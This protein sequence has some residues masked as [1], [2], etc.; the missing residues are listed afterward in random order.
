MGQPF[1]PLAHPILARLALWLL[2]RTVRCHLLVTSSVL[3]SACHPQ[4]CPRRRVRREEVWPW[5][6]LPGLLAPHWA[7]GCSHRGVQL[8]QSPFSVSFPLHAAHRL[9]RQGACLGLR[10]DPSA[11]QWG[12]AVPQ[13]HAFRWAALAGV[14]LQVLQRWRVSGFGL[15]FPQELWD[16]SSCPS[17]HHS[18][19]LESCSSS[20]PRSATRAFAGKINLFPKSIQV[21][22]W[23]LSTGSSGA[24]SLLGEWAQC[25]SWC[26]C[27]GCQGL[28]AFS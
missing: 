13:A 21:W 24:W 17:G 3:C 12:L 15:G 11:A 5:R 26:Q 9:W 10:S 6:V 27:D 7:S 25:S 1:S 18:L 28:G 8:L 2:L 4:L 20:T 16:F 23:V 22:T 19:A 14:F